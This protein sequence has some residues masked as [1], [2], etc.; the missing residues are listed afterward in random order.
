MKTRQKIFCYIV[1][2]IALFLCNSAVLADYISSVQLSADDAGSGELSIDINYSG[3]I[4]ISVEKILSAGNIMIT[5]VPFQPVVGF[6]SEITAIVDDNDVRIGKEYSYKIKI[7]NNS[8]M[9]IDCGMFTVGAERGEHQAVPAVSALRADATGD[10]A[11]SDATTVSGEGSV[12]NICVTNNGIYSIAASN[13]AEC[14]I[15]YTEGDITNAIAYTNIL[16]TCRGDDIAWLAGTNNESLIFYGSAMSTLYQAGNIYQLRVG[17]GSTILQDVVVSASPS[18]G[19]SFVE[20][21]HFEKDIPGYYTKGESRPPPLSDF[22]IWDYWWNSGGSKSFNLYLPDVDDVNRAGVISTQFK[23]YYK[24]DGVL[25]NNHVRISCNGVVVSDTYFTGWDTVLIQSPVTNLVSGTNVV[26]IE[27]LLD[28]GVTSI[29]FLESID[30]SYTRKFKAY[31]DR[32]IFN[33]GAY[34]NITVSGFSTNQITLWNITDEEHPVALQ[35]G[36][37]VQ[38]SNG[39]YSISFVPNGVS[40]RYIVGAENIPPILRGVKEIDLL[41]SI[42]AADYIVIA[43]DGFS[44]GIIPLM[45]QR[46]AQGLK[47][48]LLDVEQ[49][50]TAFSYGF[51]TPYAIKDFLSYA[52]T[53]WSVA[54]R[55]V[56]LAGAG[57][58]DFCDK[59]RNDPWDPCLIPPL[60]YYMNNIDSTEWI[61][62]DAPFGD[63]T[64]DVVPEIIVGRLPAADTNELAIIVNKI[65]AYEKEAGMNWKGKVAMLADNNDPAGDFHGDSDFLSGIISSNR[66]IEKIYLTNS[67]DTVWVRSAI[68]DRVNDGTGF[69]SYLGHG[70]IAKLADED[71]INDVSAFT[72]ITMPSVMLA[73]TCELG[74]FALPA[75][76]K[77]GLMEQMIVSGDGGFVG[78]WAPASLSY[79]IAGFNMASSLFDTVFKDNAIRIGDAVKYAFENFSAGASYNFLLKTFEFQGDPATIIAPGPYSFDGWRKEY[80]TDAELTNSVIVAWDADP[81]G[82]GINNLEEYNSGTNPTNY[83]ERIEFSGKMEP[84][85]S[86]NETNSYVSLSFPQV[87]WSLD[88]NMYVDMCCDLVTNNNWTDATYLFEKV[89]QTEL[90]KSADYMTL[91]LLTTNIMDRKAF[92]RTRTVLDSE[93]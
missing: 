76:V 68:V 54:P 63:V 25:S 41:S 91:H 58:W 53:N 72:N 17:T 65:L 49:V 2:I 24:E 8:G 18:N 78:G 85:V 50:Y 86:G 57:N 7:Y 83:N 74:R 77:Q 52:Y 71:L 90:N 9:I 66:P 30:V 19:Q 35:S 29:F 62:V 82:D 15:G 51:I 84:V 56:V 21:L 46:Q 40:N 87:K 11:L 28:T 5:E 47:T 44:D 45:E 55:Y 89:G 61:G 60:M 26:S 92:F 69:L 48:M 33:G 32:L 73:F 16:L 67:V 27:Q 6:G 34:S 36:N 20:N 23:G 75:G 59:E 42:N 64:G 70:N 43:A 3:I 31:N 10:S 80:F 13:I 38:D 12:I 37:I 88:V 22:W 14:L 1:Y 93:L 4:G 39:M 81:D 79:E